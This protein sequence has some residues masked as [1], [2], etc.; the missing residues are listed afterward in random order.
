MIRAGTHVR[1]GCVLVC[2]ASSGPHQRISGPFL[3]QPLLSTK[4]HVAVGQ[5]QWDPIVVGRCTIHFR[6][7][8]SGGYDLA[9]DPFLNPTLKPTETGCTP[10]RSKL[11]REAFRSERREETQEPMIWD[12]WCPFGGSIGMGRRCI[13][14]GCV[15]P[16]LV[17]FT[18]PSKKDNHHIRTPPKSSPLRFVK[19]RWFIER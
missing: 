5:N 8:S 7:Y 2:Q 10:E 12:V 15:C 14:H 4:P 13:K 16:L 6:T 1:A 11:R 9:F 3:D 17:V 18:G 19:T